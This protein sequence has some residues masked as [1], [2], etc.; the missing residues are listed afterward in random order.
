MVIYITFLLILL[1]GSVSCLFLG[2]RPAA[3]IVGPLAS[4]LGGAAGL[5]AALAGGSWDAPLPWSVPMGSF[6]V[7]MDGLSAFF[8]CVISL[9]CGVAGLYGGAYM[10]RAAG[11]K[12]VGASWFFYLVLFAS[13]A[14]VVAA[15]NA[16]LFLVAWEAMS[17]SSFFLVLFDSERPGVLEAGWTYLV[18][19][20]L[21]TAFLLA[22]FLLMGSGDSLEFKA[23]AESG[24]PAGAI[25]ILAVVGFGTKAGLM[26]M[27]VW[28]PLAHPAAPSHV[29]AVMSGV[30][31]KTGIYGLLRVL[32]LLPAPPEWWGWTL[33]AIGAGSGILGVLFALAQQDLKQLLAYS[34]VENVGII[35]MGIGLGLLGRASGMEAMAALGFCGAILHVLNHSIFKSMLFLGAGSALHGAGGGRL[36]RLGGLF[37]RMGTTGTTFLVASAAICG[38]PPLNGFVGEFCIYLASLWPLAG[39]AGAWPVWGGIVV[40]LS[41]AI[42]GGL[43]VACFAKAFGI[44]FLGEPR[45]A[46]AAAAHESPRAMRFAMIF[47]AVL[48]VALGLAGPLAVAAARPITSLLLGAQGDNGAA[49]AGPL[50]ALWWISGSAVALTAVVAGLAILRRRLLA[51]RHVAKAGTWDCGYAAP[52]ARMQYTATSFASPIVGMFRYILRPAEEVRPPQGILPREASARTR[53]D[54]IFAERLFRPIFMAVRWSASRLRWMQ[55]GRNQLY[56]LYIALAAVALLAWKLGVAK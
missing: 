35:A 22:M 42:I 6:H 10:A 46:E 55:Q 2:R 12:N 47:L 29:S 23:L 52:T 49:A 24:G 14:I 27:H 34:S 20:H 41:M 39:G 26:P 21:G 30:M 3:N 31:I 8:L 48:C 1:A 54:D 18:A 36:D 11:R 28:L 56:V 51:H 13:M 19:T 25:F 16:V 33:V 38:L 50:N 7:A 5:I 44:V 43:A 9:I 15:R 17:L 40:A 37:K 53:T 32:T 4:M 45:S